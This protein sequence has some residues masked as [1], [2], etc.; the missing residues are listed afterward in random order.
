MDSDCARF[1]GETRDRSLDFFSDFCQD[2]IGELVDDNYDIRQIAV[3]FFRLRRRCENFSLYSTMPR[4]PA[5][6]RSV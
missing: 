3:T 4:T 2:Q 6:E 5:S 1:C